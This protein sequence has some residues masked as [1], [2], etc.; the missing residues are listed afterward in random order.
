MALPAV[1]VFSPLNFETAA[2]KHYPVYIGETKFVSK[3]DWSAANN[4][5][6]TDQSIA[7]YY[8]G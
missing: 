1:S 3:S 4:S 6:F 7:G 5:S 8:T 2:A